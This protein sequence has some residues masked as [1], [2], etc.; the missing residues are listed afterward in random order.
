MQIKITDEELVGHEELLEVKGR[1]EFADVML[2][3][4]D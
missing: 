3:N 1:A 4:A 2:V